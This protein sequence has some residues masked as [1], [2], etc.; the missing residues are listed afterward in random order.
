MAVF[1][2]FGHGAEVH[3]LSNED[4]VQMR[5]TSGPASRALPINEAVFSSR[6]AR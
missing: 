1:P 3:Q 5:M 4:G 6:H 2:G